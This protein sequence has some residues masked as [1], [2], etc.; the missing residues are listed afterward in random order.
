MLLYPEEER[1]K[2]GAAFAS[3]SFSLQTL[4][5]SFL[6]CCNVPGSDDGSRFHSSTCV[7]YNYTIYLV[8]FWGK[9]GQQSIVLQVCT[10]CPK[11]LLQ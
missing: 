7:V 11:I 10:I 2:M 3:I 9:A 4:R 1:G 8:L 5:R 6:Q